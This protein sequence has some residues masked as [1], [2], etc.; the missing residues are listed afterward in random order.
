MPEN[1]EVEKKKIIEACSNVLTVSHESRLSFDS[2]VYSKF[3]FYAGLQWF[4]VNQTNG[5]IRDVQMRGDHSGSKIPRPVTNVFAQYADHL[6]SF[7]SKIEP[8]TR[9]FPTSSTDEDI[10]SAEVADR[11]LPAIDEEIELEPVRDKISRLLVLS[12]NAF[13]LTGDENG[14]FFTDVLSPLQVFVEDMGTEKLEDQETI[15]IVFAKSK[16]YIQEQYGNF[17]SA[18]EADL[19][20]M[21]YLESIPYIPASAIS[22]E[23]G[24]TDRF[25]GLCGGYGRASSGNMGYIKQVWRKPSK[26][27]PGGSVCKIVGGKIV[28][29]PYRW[30]TDGDRRPF[31]PMTHMKFDPIPGVFFGRS[32]MDRVMPLQMA[33]NKAVAKIQMMMS[34]AGSPVFSIPY[35]TTFADKTQDGI[36]GRTP[37]ETVVFRNV[38]ENS[39]RPQWLEAPQISSSDMKYISDI[40]TKIGDL[41]SVVDVLRGE[42][43]YSGTPDALVERMIKQ[44]LTRYGPVM[45]SIARSWEKMAKA[46]L[47]IFRANPDRTIVGRALKGDAGVS[48]DFFRS[49]QL[50]G[51]IDITVETDSVTPKSEVVEAA[52]FQTAV[53]LG[54]IDLKD[55]VARYKAL[56]DLGRADLAGE[57]DSQ[58]KSAVAENES[59]LRGAIGVEA[60]PFVH[61][62]DVHIPIHTNVAASPRTP[63]QA[64]AEMQAHIKDHLLKKIYEQQWIQQQSQPPAVDGGGVASPEGEVFEGEAEPEELPQGEGFEGPPILAPEDS[65]GEGEVAFDDQLQGGFNG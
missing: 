8:N 47:E 34:R 44:G 14:G 45:R 4:V 17:E 31:L 18:L 26:S 10:L 2:S 21:Q 6:V 7:L 56:K 46:K 13:T 15:V 35:G 3:L 48:V 64:V 41:L 51:G 54:L 59:M 29:G 65:I 52:K 22:D 38:G 43:G 58:Y 50:T 28:D 62:H 19:L 20:S 53:T 5:S 37:G 9:A 55:P 11:V 39:G 16:D 23:G 25:W 24:A 57:V 33:R 1:M 30:P 36:S 49:A 60:I 63:P 61:D 42:Q 40:D 32:P 27:N 12:G